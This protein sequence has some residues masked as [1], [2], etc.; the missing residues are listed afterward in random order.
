MG[1]RPTATATASSSTA[2]DHEAGAASRLFS[3]ITAGVLVGVLEVVLAS[4][5]AALVLG[6]DGALHLPAVLGFNLFGATV[7]MAVIAVRSSIPGVVGS[8][9]DS[10]AAI[11]ALMVVSIT[12]DM[13]G[14]LYDTFLTILV[15]IVIAT[16]ATGAF[17]LL[18][19]RFRLGKLVRFVPYPVIGGFMAGT[20]WVLFVGGAELLA[21][22]S[23][24]LQNLSEWVKAEQ[25]VKWAP[26]VGFAIVL[27]FLVRRFR[28]YLIIPGAVVGG[29]LLF[30]GFLL[31]TGVTPLVAKVRGWL[32][33]PFPFG[34]DLFD[35]LTPKAFAG[36]N[37]LEVLGAVPHILTLLIVAA[38]ALLLNASG[39]E[40]ARGQDADIDR[41]L[42][43]AGVAN[44]A[45]SV[46]GGIVGFQA[47]SFTALAQRTGSS[48]RLVG[49]VGAAI[50]AA[51]LVFGAEPLSLFPRWVLGG[52]VVFLGLSFLVEWL[53]DGWFRLARRDYVVVVLIVLAVAVLGF[54]PG[55]AVGLVLA[56]VL[57][58]VD[59]SRTDVVRDELT[60]TQYRSNVDRSPQHMEV[61]RS[62]GDRIRILRLHGFVFFGTANTLLERIRRLVKDVEGAPLRFLVIDFQRV[63][64]VDTSAGLAFAQAHALAQ[65]RGFALVFAG[66]SPRTRLHLERAGFHER[67][68]PNL[69]T[70][71]DLDHASEWCED[72]LLEEH[73]VEPAVP[74]GPFAAQL[75]DGLGLSVEPGRLMPYLEPVEVGEG[76]EVIRQGDRADDLYFLER[77]RLTTVFHGAS[78]ET[79]RLRT[80]GPGTVVGEVSLYLAGVRTASVTAEIPSR[81]YRLSRATLEDMERRDPE[82]AADLHRALATLLSRRLSESLGAL[83]SLLR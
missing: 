31:A 55:V 71:S 12:D 9:Q 56:I 33:G 72:R 2:G 73:G 41:E 8:L 32:L 69:K 30:Y 54:L 5:F 37:W 7:I 48:S 65:A 40:L 21:E 4:S 75:R 58:V 57:F 29:V 49:V 60:A 39:I 6:E 13:G 81:L 70:F 16:A 14:G 82:A 3:T 19:G 27:L 63:I 24:D 38:M 44:L 36:A 28:H 74:P 11:L 51:T 34:S 83:D 42:R 20:G 10:T 46:G 76:E 53:Y 50:C 66:L 26:G 68:L 25:V 15:A 64:G 17:F 52:L 35:F 1:Q 79:V 43:A 59:Y 23:L 45:S 18:M 61:L 47:L 67:D 77:G 80:M 22:V 78:G 62:E